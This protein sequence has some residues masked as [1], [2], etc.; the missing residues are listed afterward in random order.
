MS[1]Q[2][3]V[4]LGSNYLGYGKSSWTWVIN[5]K[6]YKVGTVKT[7]DEVDA[8]LSS[9]SNFLDDIPENRDIVI[10][11]RHKETIA[12]ITNADK[13]MS[14]LIRKVR[15]QLK[16][17]G[18]VKFQY[19]SNGTPQRSDVVASKLAATVKDKVRPAPKKRASPKSRPTGIITTELD[20]D[21]VPTAM[22]GTTR[23]S[24]PVLCP[25]CDMPVHPLTMECGCSN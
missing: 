2:V 10:R 1:G 16:R 5:D 23:G 7:K 6:Q 14:P 15:R 21:Y 3:V 8:E 25:S 22:T 4:S 24:K 20:E 19:Q 9:L 13:T 17:S 11:V 18:A 12:R